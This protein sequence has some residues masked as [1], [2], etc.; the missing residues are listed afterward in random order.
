MRSLIR[1]STVVSLVLAFALIAGAQRKEQGKAQPSPEDQ[2]KMMAEYQ[3][4]MNPG[5]GQ[6]VLAKMAGDWTVAGEVWMDPKSDPMPLKPGTMHSEMI[7]G[8]RYLQSLQNS[9]MMGMPYE[10]HG[11]AGFDN[12]RQ[13]YQMTWVDNM[14]TVISTGTGTLDPTGKILT[15]MGKMDEPTK[16]EKDNDVKYVY[17]FKDDKTISF[18]MYGPAPTGSLYK[19]MEMTYT[20]K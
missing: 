8:G 18:E 1:V 2:Q 10:G 9:E 4:Y 3:K 15:Y 20:K 17:T 11:L 14:G 6:E 13:Q 16:N 12:Y 19:M 5:K 7:L